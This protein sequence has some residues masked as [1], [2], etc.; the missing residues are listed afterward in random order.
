MAPKKKKKKAASNPARGFSTVSVAS[1]VKALDSGDSQSASPDQDS[2]SANTKPSKLGTPDAGFQ[3]TEDGGDVAIQDMSPE[4]L[5]A[6]LEDAEL[7]SLLTA[8][9]ARCKSEVTRQVGRLHTERRQL[10]QQANHL[11]T[12]SWLDHEAVG[13]ILATCPTTAERPATMSSRTGGSDV[14]GTQRLPEL[15]VLKRVL[16]ALRFNNITQCLSHVILLALTGSIALDTDLAWGLAEAVDWYAQYASLDEL[17]DY[18]VD[19]NGVDSLVADDD[20]S[21]HSGKT[22]S[23]HISVLLSLAPSNV[24]C[25][26]A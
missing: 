16:E 2:S 12:L 25:Y 18:D 14:I 3:P 9:A 5:E 15:W 1:K 8:S 10:R 24:W 4:Q 19:H 20:V 6:H 26:Y 21:D 22:N 13:K 11:N 7:Q 23:I 17:P